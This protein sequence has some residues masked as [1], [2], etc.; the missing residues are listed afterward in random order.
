MFTSK[1]CLAC[2]GSGACASFSLGTSC[3]CDCEKAQG[4]GPFY[5]RTE[6][7][8]ET[9]CSKLKNNS[10]TLQLSTLKGKL[11]AAVWK[12]M[13]CCV[14]LEVWGSRG[15]GDTEPKTKGSTKPPHVAQTAPLQGVETYGRLAFG[16]PLKARQHESPGTLSGAR[17]GRVSLSEIPPV[18]LRSPLVLNEHC[19]TAVWS[20]AEAEEPCR[21]QTGYCL[22]RLSGGKAL[23]AD[24]KSPAGLDFSNFS[25]AAAAMRSV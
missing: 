25:T 18:P 24:R 15:L 13:F 16:G 2:T 5:S 11:K 23:R 20:G 17:S 9:V 6:T 22:R 4:S 19:E 14:S 8:Q 21:M 3:G 7:A 1:P 10:R 12:G